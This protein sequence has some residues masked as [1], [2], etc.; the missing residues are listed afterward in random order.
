MQ[1]AATKWSG[2][3]GERGGS[4]TLRRAA[5]VRPV[6]AGVA[7]WLA[8]VVWTAGPL[9]GQQVADTSYSPPIERPTFSPG[10][11]PLVLIDEAHHNFHTAGGR[12]RAFA[13][14]LR[15]DGYV[16]EPSGE[17]FTPATLVRARVLVIANAIADRNVEDWS[18]PT[19]SAFTPHEIQAVAEWVRGGGALLLIADHMPIAGNTEALAAAFGL[20]FQNGF[21]FDSLTGEG[22]AIFRRSDGGLRPHPITDGR[23]PAERVDSVVTFTGQAFRA[24]PDAGAEP[25]LVLPESFHLFLPPVAWEFSDSTPR[26]SA[27]YL[28][29]GA[30]LRFGEGRVAAFGEAAMFSAQLAGE[31]LVPMGMNDPAAAQNYRFALNV[32]RWLVGG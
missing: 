24:D 32:V 22:R 31:E 8:S 17:P 27:A 19:P 29:Q 1:R 30:A 11:G 20:R 14:L 4:V 12:Y 5:G 18:L 21:A 13:D 25:L 6:S 9:R 26:V 28:L 15:R 3:D 7:A 16:V 10:A 2:A 23:G